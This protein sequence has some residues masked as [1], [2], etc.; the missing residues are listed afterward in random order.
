MNKPTK[1]LVK[2]LRNYRNVSYGQFDQEIEDEVEETQDAADLIEEMDE[3][4]QNI[5]RELIA[6][7]N[8]NGTALYFYERVV[9]IFKKYE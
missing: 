3:D 7:S 4:I 2:A 9:K 1:Y 8:S 5:H 6:I